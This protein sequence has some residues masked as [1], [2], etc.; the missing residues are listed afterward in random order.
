VAVFQEGGAAVRWNENPEPDIA[1]YDVYRKEE[2]E[3][4]FRRMN[5]QLMKEPYFLD[6]TADP[7]KSY[8][9]RLR[10]ADTSGKE[11]DFSKDAEVSP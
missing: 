7:K 11:S 10:A 2:G 6:R 1:G 4:A 5:P 8:I 9:Y 3:T